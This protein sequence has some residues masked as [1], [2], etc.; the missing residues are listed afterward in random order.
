MEYTYVNPPPGLTCF[1]N[2]DTLHHPGRPDSIIRTTFGFDVIKKLL[3]TTGNRNRVYID[4]KHMDIKARVQYYKYLA[5]NNLQVPIIFS[6]GA[7][8]GKN[9]ALA[10][11][12]GLYPNFDLYEE[13]K[14]PYDLGT[15]RNECIKE[16]GLSYEM[17]KL[18][19]F[20]PW[21]I[22][23]ADEE[24]PVIYNSG[25]I[26]G[27]TLDERIPGGQR[28]NYKKDKTKLD[29]YIKDHLMNAAD[30]KVF[31]H[32]QPFFRNLFYLVEHCGKTDATAWD[33]LVIGA[34]FD[35]FIK[36]VEYCHTAEEIPSLRQL[37][38]KFLPVYEDY[39]YHNNDLS[40]KLA[41]TDIADRL[42]FKNGEK[43]ALKYY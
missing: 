21:S 1:D 26:I 35:G 42:I 29:N 13:V 30:A 9:L 5:D 25:G 10:T 22:N 24:I 11:Y 23:L 8:S 17:N 32:M 43:F 3:D 39:V 40:Y 36:P 34:D 31:S 4:V 14:A 18:G 16:K 7:V 12:T 2:R 38:I 37:I 19:W 33:H 6:H 28:P 41:P 20:Y 27:I 15:F